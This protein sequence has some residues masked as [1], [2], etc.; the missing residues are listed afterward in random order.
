MKCRSLI[1][2]QFSWEMVTAVFSPFGH[3]LELLA[4]PSLIST[5][6]GERILLVGSE[7][8]SRTATEPFK[9]CRPSRACKVALRLPTLTE[10]GNSI[11]SDLHFMASTYCSATET[12]RSKLLSLTTSAKI[13]TI[14]WWG[15]STVTG[16]QTYLSKRAC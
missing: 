15:I 8:S 1:S 10:T 13:W 7:S 6:M 4:P 11:W 2:Q 16:N 3:Q 5:A 14:L 12:E 9:L